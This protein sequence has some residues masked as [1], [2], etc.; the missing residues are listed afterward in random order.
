MFNFRLNVN[1]IV[2]PQH[3]LTL[4]HSGRP[5]FFQWLELI[6]WFGYPDIDKDS[7]LSVGNWD[8]YFCYDK[9]FLPIYIYLPLCR[10]IKVYL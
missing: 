8:W 7:F 3:L 1:S 2:S 6:S 4:K 9:Y 5:L 10:F